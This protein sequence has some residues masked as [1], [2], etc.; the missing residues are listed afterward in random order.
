M[1]TRFLEALSI[2]IP[3]RAGLEPNW[4]VGCCL[5]SAQHSCPVLVL[6]LL[7]LWRLLSV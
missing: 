2:F 4:V 1:L 5:V 6:R 7:L 3:V